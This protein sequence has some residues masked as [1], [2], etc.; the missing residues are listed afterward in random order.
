MTAFVELDAAA[1]LVRDGDHLGVGGCGFS[2]LPLALVQAVADRS[3]RGLTYVAWG[4][5]L[6]LE[7][8][9]ARDS[10]RKLVF[11]FSSL[12]V[13]GL[14]PR[15]RGALERGTIE[16]EELPALA[17]VQGFQAQRHRVPSLAFPLP[18]GSDV[19]QR[20]TLTR[21]HP[22]PVTGASV[23]STGALALD[24][25]LLHAQRADEDGNVELEG[26]LGQ[27]LLGPCTTKRLLVSVEEIVPRGALQRR[28]RGAILPH[29]LVTAVVHAPLGAYPSA[30]LPF[31]VADYRAIAAMIEQESL[32]V[33]RA[34]ERAAIARRAASTPHA[35]VMATNGRPRSAVAGPASDAER[36]VVTLAREYTNES[37]ASAGAVSPVALASYLLAKRTHA[38]RMTIITT[39]GGYIDVAA[40]PMLLGLGEALDFETAVA[41]AS[42]DDTYHVFYQP[43][44]VSHEVVAVAQ[45]DGRARVNTIEVRTPSGRRV[46]L[47]GQGGMADVAD[48]HQHFVVYI[49]RHSPLTLV[50]EVDVVS[51]SRSLLTDDERRVAGLRPGAVKLVTNLCTFTVD[52]ATRRLELTALQPGVTVEDVRAETGFEVM[53]GAGCA[54]LQSPT[55]EELAIL[56]SEVDPLGI[57]RLELVPARERGALLEEL[58]DGEDRWIA[59]A[60]A[61]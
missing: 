4:G 43:G 58:F 12:D 35:R 7:L 25:L 29:A 46:R 26:T 32:A 59:E 15:F 53:V 31:Y 5:G 49:P 44:R 11:C 19:L 3:P 45:I 23:G 36:L 40:R 39:A 27:D 33:P 14:A 22:D 56:R 30:C 42:G 48:M 16:V 57:S 24:T 21:R 13:F 9:L 55:A 60:G 47:P 17:M 6:P 52:H 1:A 37:V 28:R 2:R 18:H 61:A 50:D 51:A 10:V 38:P 41:H 34:G 20:T 8:L 54:E